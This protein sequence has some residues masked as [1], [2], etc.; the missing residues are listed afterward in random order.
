M[1]PSKKCRF[2]NVSGILQDVVMHERLEHGALDNDG[3]SFSSISP[4]ATAAVWVTAP[5]GLT[6][7]MDIPGTT[8]E[9]AYIFSTITGAKY[10]Y[11]TAASSASSSSWLVPDTRI[12]Y[13]HCLVSVL[14]YGQAT[15]T[16]DATVAAGA[17]TKVKFVVDTQSSTGSSSYANDYN[18]GY[19]T[20]RITCVLGRERPP[21]QLLSLGLPETAHSTLCSDEQFAD[22]MLDLG[23][24]EAPI[25]NPAQLLVMLASHALSLE[26]LARWVMEC[27]C[28]NNTN[29]M[30]AAAP[31]Q[32]PKP[33]IKAIYHMLGCASEEWDEYFA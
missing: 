30:D 9:L 11:H 27:N 6:N 33:F 17:D 23:L 21:I 19:D 3:S 4:A 14:A 10:T 31:P 8:A 16:D 18:H 20:L 28:N 15:G 2:C 1:G 32:E 25:V 7:P 5:E 29:G 24:S 26:E 12:H 22:I 13:E